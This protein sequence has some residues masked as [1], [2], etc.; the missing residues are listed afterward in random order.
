MTQEEIEKKILL[1]VSEALPDFTYQKSTRLFVRNFNLGQH[2]FHI[3]LIK[4]S[5]NQT[6]MAAKI[7]VFINEIDEI[8]MPY[9]PNFS[10]ADKWHYSTI[11]GNADVLI[12]N[13]WLIHGFDKNYKVL[14][15]FTE[16]YI[17][18][19]KT[20]F[21]PWFE[22]NSDI[23]HIFKV[24]SDNTHPDYTPAAFH[25]ES[26]VRLAILLSQRKWDDYN[27]VEAKLLT[28]LNKR[29]GK[30]FAPKVAPVVQGLRAKIEKIKVRDL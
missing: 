24:L 10:P 8:Y 26:L 28:Y 17:A 6:K 15:Q 21:M 7:K 30:Q 23:D 18:A 20:D 25:Q 9:Y 12:R 14:E 11:G 2:A 13:N 16:E 3:G 22:R 5:N 4:Q 1:E 19:I 27:Q 29:Y